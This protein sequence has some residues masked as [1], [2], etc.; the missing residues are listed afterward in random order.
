MEKLYTLYRLQCEE[1][2]TSMCVRMH[3]WVFVGSIMVELYGFHVMTIHTHRPSTG[4]G[5]TGKNVH[6][7]RLPF[8]LS[9]SKHERRKG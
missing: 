7:V 6:G 1:D 3:Q 5:R 4:S 2:D 9:L 8:V